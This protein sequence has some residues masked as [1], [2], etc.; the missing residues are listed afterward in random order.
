MN[1]AKRQAVNAWIRTSGE[2]DAVI[3]F[4]RV[5]RD[6]NAPTRILAAYDSGDHGH[7][8]DEGYK[9]MSDAIN[10]KLFTENHCH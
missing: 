3:D 5:L 4:D 9:K 6:P 8:N 10:L 2:Y 7:P 1:E